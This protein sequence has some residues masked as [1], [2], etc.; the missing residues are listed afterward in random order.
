MKNIAFFLIL[1]LLYIFMVSSLYAQMPDSAG[2]GFVQN[3]GQLLNT[4]SSVNTL[5]KYYARGGGA[6]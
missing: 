6:I 5:V 1:L 4:D 2:I 3:Q